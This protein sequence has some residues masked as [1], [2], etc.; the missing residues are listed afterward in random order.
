MGKCANEFLYFQFIGT[1]VVRSKELDNADAV[2]VLEECGKSAAEQLPVRLFGSSRCRQAVHQ[3][4]VIEGA[5]TVAAPGLIKDLAR[6]TQKDDLASSAQ[7]LHAGVGRQSRGERR[8]P[9]LAQKILRQLPQGLCDSDL[10]IMMC[11]Q[12]LGLGENLP[13]L[14]VIDD[15]VRTCASR[16]DPDSLHFFL[17]P[18]CF[19]H[20]FE[21]VVVQLHHNI[22]IAAGILV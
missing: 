22:I 8:L 4:Y 7:I 6:N 5:E 12:R 9:A 13:C 2:A 15:G 20:L 1:A 19:L 16:V 11:G 18:F 14:K 3:Q 17:H 10:E 21:Y